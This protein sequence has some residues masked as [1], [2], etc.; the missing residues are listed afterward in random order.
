M[1]IT[2]SMMSNQLINNVND[3]LTNISTLQNQASTGNKFNLPSQDP[4]DAVLT[5]NYNAVLSQL[6]SY[7]SSLDQTQS[8]YQGYDNI[9]GQ[10]MSAAEQVNSLVVQAANGTNTPSDRAAIASQV[11]EIRNTIAQFGS[12]NV[13]GNYMFAGASNSNPVSS[14][15]S[16]GV[17]TYYYTSN[18][19]TSAN[20][21]LNIGASTLKSNV[22]VTELYGYTKTTSGGATQ[23]SS[24]ISYS[25]GTGGTIQTGLL[26]NIINDLNTNNV[27]NLQN[28]LGDLQSYENSLSKVTTQIGAQEQSIQ[29][30][31]TSNQSLNTY[32]TQLVS[33][34]Q[35]ADMTKVLSNLSLEETVYQAAL[36]TGANAM[37]PTLANFLKS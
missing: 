32:V 27:S 35:G 5:V 11:A 7:Q 8:D 12:T 14:I 25:T 16:G 26:D 6:N 34:A 10:I 28:D 20:L 36:E 24:L 15:V 33:S 30:L 22:N 13:N 19:A 23:A 21:T 4:S 2:Q 29:S 3:V 1:R 37:L 18:S 17:T 9:T 31:I